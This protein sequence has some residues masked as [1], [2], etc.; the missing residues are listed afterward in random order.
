MDIPEYPFPASSSGLTSLRPYPTPRQ[1]V[2]PFF[3]TRDDHPGHLKFPESSLTCP[4]IDCS[5]NKFFEKSFL[6]TSLT[7]LPWAALSYYY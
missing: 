7:K 3:S 5:V 2:P 4:S 6:S 1:S